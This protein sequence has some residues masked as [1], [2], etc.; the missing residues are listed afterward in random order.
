MSFRL[1][2]GSM[3]AIG[4]LNAF[5]RRLTRKALVKQQAR[6]AKGVGA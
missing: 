6:R 5:S 1:V 3:I 4:L 2:H